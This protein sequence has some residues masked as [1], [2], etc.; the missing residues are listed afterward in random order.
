MVL[1]V[2]TLSLLL[3]VGFPTS[4]ATVQGH[5]TG[6]HRSKALYYAP[7]VLAAVREAYKPTDYS[8]MANIGWWNES[9]IARI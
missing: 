7:H 2:A 9:A 6:S 5:A 1:G 8:M 4:R 3:L